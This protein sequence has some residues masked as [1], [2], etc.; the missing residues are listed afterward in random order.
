MTDYVNEATAF[1]IETDSLMWPVSVLGFGEAPRK[2]DKT[3]PDGRPTYSTGT[4]LRVQSKDGSIRAD[5]TASVN[6][7]E[8]LE[9][10]EIGVEYIS[11][12]TVF[13][14]PYQNDARRL[15]YYITVEKLVP[16]TSAK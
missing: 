4:I 13:V 9:A 12:G 10:Y 6:V 7:I 14:Q 15:V 8:P 2:R 5:K 3:A 1:P 11:A 16:R